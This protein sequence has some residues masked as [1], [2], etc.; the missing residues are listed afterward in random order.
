MI[1]LHTVLTILVIGFAG[2][3]NVVRAA[4]PFQNPDANSA[5]QEKKVNDKQAEKEQ[6]EKE[7]QEAK[8]AKEKARAEAKALADRIPITSEYDRFQNISSLSFLWRT[9]DIG[10]YG[11]FELYWGSSYIYSGTVVNSNGKTVLLLQYNRYNSFSE[12]PNHHLELIVDGERIDLGEFQVT[13]KEAIAAHSIR[14][15]VAS[16][17]PFETLVKLGNAKLIEARF[18]GVEFTLKDKIISAMHDLTDRVPRS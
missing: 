14:V 8:N 2:A 18:G 15:T 17:I 3:M 16:L 6:K 1:Y 13:G 12:L 10:K 5:K 9:V 4:K 11:F 7:K